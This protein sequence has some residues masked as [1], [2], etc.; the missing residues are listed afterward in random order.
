MA[1]PGADNVWVGR[2]VGVSAGAGPIRGRPGVGRPSVVLMRQCGRGTV[3]ARERGPKN[4]G[5]PTALVNQST[6]T[7]F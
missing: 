1:K 3:V 4:A 5:T 6:R 2:G 7:D